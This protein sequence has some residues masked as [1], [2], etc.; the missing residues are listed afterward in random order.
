MKTY[1]L[2]FIFILFM[3]PFEAINA[4]DFFRKLDKNKIITQQN[5]PR[6]VK[7]LP[8]KYE[9]MSFDIDRFNNHVSLQINPKKRLIK[10]P[11]ATGSLSL[12]LLEESS[13]FET[14]LAQKFPMIKSYSAQGID[15]PTSVAK[16]SIGLDGFHAVIFSG[17]EETYYIDP[18]S[19]DSKTLMVYKNSHLVPDKDDFTCQVE[20]FR[21][22]SV[23]QE[24]S[25][26]NVNDGKLRTFRLALA[27]TGEYAQFHLTNQNIVL[28]ATEEEKKAA[29]LS[30]MNT[31]MTRVNGVF[32][33]DLAVK[34]VL[35]G[36][37]DKI[38]FLDAATD[39][40]SNS[41]PGDLIEESQ[42]VCDT[43]IGSDNYDIGHTFSTGGGGLAGLG[44]VCIQGQKARGITGSTSPIGDA[45]D[46]DYVAHEIG[47]QFGANHTQNNDCQRNT[48][49][50]VEPGSGS[51]IMGYAGICSPNVQPK[52]DT[53]FH[54]VSIAEMSSTI[55]V[56]A[57]C[58]SI[59]DAGNN[60][61]TAN[62]GANFSIPAGTPFVLR[63]IATDADGLSS[64]TY[65]W[66]QT[67]NQVAT[68]PPVATNLVGPLF[69]SLLPSSSPNR[70]MPALATVVGGATSSRWEVLP[71]VARD[72]NFS[73]L[74]RDNNNGGGSSARDDMKVSVT[75][76]APF[77]VT[78]PNSAIN[79]D[80]GTTQT[81]TW[82]K[83]T[84]DVLPINCQNVTIRLSI[85]GGI[86]FPITLKEN[87]PNDGSE[88]IVI[89]NTPSATSR[90]MVEAADHIFY[91]VNPTNFTI[92]SSTPTYIIT[93]LNDVQS[94]CYLENESI[95]YVLNFDFINGFSESVSLS[96]SGFPEGA[97]V[98]FN[99]TTISADGNVTMTISNLNEASAQMYTMNVSGSS[100]VNKQIDVQLNVRNS[101]FT[102]SNLTLP[103][104]GASEIGLSPELKWDSD[105]NAANYDVEVAS[106]SNF[107]NIVSSGNVATNFYSVSG[108]TG[109]TTYHWRIKP[110]N[111]CGEGS[112]SN[113]FNF[114]TLIPSYCLSTFTDEV[115]GSE[116]LTNVTFNSINNDSENDLIDGY[117]DFT[118]I[119]TNLQRGDTH[120]MSV[121]FDT[122]GSQDNCT[123]FIDWNNDYVFDITTEKYD[124]GTG[125]DDISTKTLDIT[126]PNDALIGATRM[127]VVLEYT[128]SSPNGGGAC[129]AD[130]VYEWGETEDYTVIIEDSTASF[131][132]ETFGNF[133]L[134]P[135]PTKGE[136]TLTLNLDTTDDL[137]VQ[138]FDLRGR[139]LDEK[140]YHSTIL[141]FTERI[142]F[143]NT[144][145][146]LY[147]LK[148]INGDKQ[149]T[150]KLI[151]K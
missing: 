33:R 118:S 88:A 143:E 108:L 104:N 1:P 133:M 127:R 63:G 144:S 57:Q 87:T 50:A 8:S 70:Y 84:T 65:A 3:I 117:E 85:D 151:I 131:I 106:D 149:T 140:K 76:A 103:V 138:L 66:E 109:N 132:D 148:V 77:T 58:S 40:L 119:S 95:S 123:V 107:T 16:I 111:S 79:W 15:D 69:R 82:N 48:S 32:E 94:V 122:G 98:I 81:I 91:N 10:L 129:D 124:L 41:D 4:Q 96:V 39:E 20:A 75:N 89:P 68:M 125:Y 28:T 9:L 74:V 36:E 121:T 24:N 78:L 34:M 73:F 61:P 67:D 12:F 42:T 112:Y 126:V 23:A 150:R 62:A 116:H 27:C 105:I 101:I 22:K 80:A 128:G 141:S 60:V 142:F 97:S 114:K 93:N 52:S 46:I 110:K 59:T 47:H 102:S 136:F 13:N 43:N 37:N 26:Q 45:Y 19:K 92:N 86:T 113:A 146:G 139:L 134:F 71:T 31:T 145:A 90:I 38:I 130:H 17:Q 30:A 35:V 147:F 14:K 54:A 53:Y 5:N 115:S 100:S 18:Y 55:Q 51:T 56:S 44:V 99:P 6:Q 120:Q 137:L 11:N 2:V 135:N 25:I 7:S 29:V 83:G 49:T 72:L 64:L 21:S